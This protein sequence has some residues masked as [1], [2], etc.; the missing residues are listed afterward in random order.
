MSLLFSAMLVHG[1]ASQDL[2]VSSI[3]PIQKGK[4]STCS[5]SGNYHGIALRSLERFWIELS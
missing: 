4:G 1:V 3:I 2:L 5:D